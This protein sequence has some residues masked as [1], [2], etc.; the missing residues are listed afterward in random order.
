ML[1]FPAA[2]AELPMNISSMRIGTLVIVG[3][4]RIVLA[5]VADSETEFQIA[6]NRLVTSS[7]SYTPHRATL[8]RW[9]GRRHHDMSAGT[10]RIANVMSALLD[11]LARVAVD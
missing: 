2:L 8:G 6:A 5:T 9:L 10:G 1:M 3:S 11:A 7:A 4:S